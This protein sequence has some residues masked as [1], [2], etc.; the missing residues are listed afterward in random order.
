MNGRSP[1]SAVPPVPA[2]GARPWVIGVGNPDRGDDGVGP[3][4]VRRCERAGLGSK[5]EVRLVV[6]AG[7]STELLDLWK[8]AR[9]V[10]LVDAVVSGSPPGS[11]HRL[12]EGPQLA[13]PTWRSP[14]THAISLPEVIA[15]GRALHRLPARLVVLGVEATSFEPGSPLSPP[16]QA[17]FPDLLRALCQELDE[18]GVACPP[19]SQEVVP[20][21]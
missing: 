12:V 21:A 13:L 6:V 2:S 7:E 17:A 5:G 11:I 1:P 16:V 9:A 15:L 20:H 10:I 18:L 3:E 14:S 4:V 19:A 8:D